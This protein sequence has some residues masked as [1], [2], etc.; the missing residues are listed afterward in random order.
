MK[1]IIHDLGEQYNDILKDK[2]NVSICANGEYAPCQ[3]CFGCWTKTPAECFMKDKLK[4]VCRIIGTAD[5]LI[6]ISENCYGAYNPAV[7][8]ILDRSIGLSTPFSTYR[9][10]Q[11]HHTLRYGKRELLSVITYGDTTEAEVSTF[12]L[13]V[14]RNAVN[15]GFMKYEF[16]LCNNVEELEELL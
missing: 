6:I 5:E 3:G 4:E 14:Q 2:Y 13:M 1:I 12:E 7:K 10:K 16:H 15:F 9:A 8:N 11:M